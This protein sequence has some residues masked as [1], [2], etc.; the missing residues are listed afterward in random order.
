MGHH[1]NGGLKSGFYK[2]VAP[3]IAF[4]D[5]PDWLL[6]DET[7]KYNTPEKAQLMES[8]GAQVLSFNS[9]PNSV[10]L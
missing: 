3:K 4:F 8:L 5:A 10:K 6:F 1:G 7:G 2:A 9:A